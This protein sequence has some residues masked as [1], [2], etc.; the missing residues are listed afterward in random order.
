[1]SE[2]ASGKI[3]EETSRKMLTIKCWNIYKILTKNY[4]KLF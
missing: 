3:L 1:M 4:Y 2:E